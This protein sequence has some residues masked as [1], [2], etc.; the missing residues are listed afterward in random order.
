MRGGLAMR[1]RRLATVAVALA[2]GLAACGGSSGGGGAPTATS[3]LPALDHHVTVNFWHAMAGGSQKPTLEQIT[4]A[5]NSSQSNVTVQLQVYP[6]YGTLLQKT[7][8]ALA[9]GNPP[10]MAQCYENWAAK[11][12]Q[13]KALA[14]I[15]PF[16][17]D[18]TGTTESDLTDVWPSMLND[19]KL[20]GT[21]YMFPFN[22]SD[23]VI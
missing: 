22:K 20:R 23:S 8:A 5:F 9:A 16:F 18:K 6:D 4:N 7:L 17:I 14:D 1:T 11:F 12:N 2:L 21:F 10:D 19:A 15:S 13:S 3:Q